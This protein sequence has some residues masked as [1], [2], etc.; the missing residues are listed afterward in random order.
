VADR[1]D[2]DDLLAQMMGELG[3]LHSQ[4]VTGDVRR[5]EDAADTAGLGARFERVDGG[6]KVTH[7]YRTEAEL[8]T[9]RGPLQAPDTDVRV[10]DVIVAING[11]PTDDARDL[12][13]LLRNRAGQQ[14]LL[15]VR[16][17]SSAP[18]RVIV[19]AVDARRE[20]ALRYGD[21]VQ[22]ARQKV[23][24]AGAGSIGYIHLF[25]MGPNDIA[26]FVR[27]FYGQ[28][29]RDGLI[30]DVRRNRGG[31]IDS[32]IIE[33]LLRRAWAF[34]ARPSGLPY[35]NMQQTFRGHLAVLTDELTYSDGETFA[36]GVKSLKLGPLIGTRTAGA[37]V[38]L[39]DGNPLVDGGRARVAE[40]PQYGMDGQWLVEGIGVEP[41]IVVENAPH[42]TF[43]GQD[44]QLDAAI[45]WLRRKLETDPIPPLVPRAIP[46]LHKDAAV[47]PAT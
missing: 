29:D 32:W 35:T 39:S 7:V 23:E 21:W 15:D 6:W 17:G 24:R 8:P 12:S 45:G 13:D 34:W 31:N 44:A 9:E 18:R 20:E 25:A 37:G 46:P 3:A 30:I 36:A 4:I 41:D 47:E 42:A 16:R 33:K 38:W 1:G 27:E 10:D 19:T 40:F 5:A 43:N 26:T 28:Y 22:A 11:R 2:L 14:V